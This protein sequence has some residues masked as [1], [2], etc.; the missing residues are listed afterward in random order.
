[1]DEIAYQL[2]QARA[3]ANYLAHDERLKD[4][5]QNCCESINKLID[6]RDKTEI[7]NSGGEGV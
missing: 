1:M 4:E 7:D 3:V 5:A 6:K 2:L